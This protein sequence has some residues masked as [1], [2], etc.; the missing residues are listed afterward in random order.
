MKNN[1]YSVVSLFTS[2][3]EF[4]KCNVIKNIKKES[5]SSICNIIKSKTPSSTIFCDDCINIIKNIDDQSIDL[6]LTDPPYNL[7][8]FMHNR[9]TNLNKMRKNQFAYSGWDNLEYDD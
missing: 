1:K 2:A 4:D 3:D 9:N 8:Q 6:I 7:G 5:I